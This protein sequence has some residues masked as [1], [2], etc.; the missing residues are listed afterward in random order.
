MRFSEVFPLFY[1]G[2]VVSIENIWIDGIRFELADDGETLL[3][4]PIPTPAP[5]RSE[6]PQS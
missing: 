4:S 3:E 1:P 2:Q 5:C 6:S